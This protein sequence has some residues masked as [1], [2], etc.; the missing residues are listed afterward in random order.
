MALLAKYEKLDIGFIPDEVKTRTVPRFE[1]DPQDPETSIHVGADHPE[2]A[3]CYVFEY[4]NGTKKFV[5]SDVAMEMFSA[6]AP[7]IE[8]EDQGAI[9]GHLFKIDPRNGNIRWAGWEGSKFE[10][11]QKQLDRIK[12]GVTLVSAKKA[13]EI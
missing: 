4:N 13:E 5:N 3:S 1:A 8:D 7:E 6:L 9:A 12:V 10:V 11:R 2:A